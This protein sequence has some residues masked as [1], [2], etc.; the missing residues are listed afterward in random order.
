MR[1][2]D[3][4][5]KGEDAFLAYM[6]KFRPGIHID[7]LENIYHAGDVTIEHISEI[8]PGGYPQD[9]YW[10]RMESRDPGKG[11]FDGQLNNRRHEIYEGI[12]TG[13][14]TGEL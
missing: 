13:R 8:P 7:R 14:I 3:K 1:F 12:R 2:I 4:I 11:Y 9:Y 5:I 6:A 10:L